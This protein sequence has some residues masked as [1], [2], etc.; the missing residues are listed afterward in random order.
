MFKM[1]IHVVAFC[2]LSAFPCNY[3]RW[4]RTKYLDIIQ[5]LVVHIEGGKKWKEKKNL[6]S[7]SGTISCLR[8]RV[9]GER[10]NLSGACLVLLWDCPWV[11]H[12]LSHLVFQSDTGKPALLR[13]HGFNSTRIINRFPLESSSMFSVREQLQHPTRMRDG[14]RAKAKQAKTKFVH[15][16]MTKSARKSPSGP[17]GGWERATL[18]GRN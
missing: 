15:I 14:D 4:D 1:R 13:I 12:C 9:R 2:P 6:G 11:L 18:A 17:M 5:N 16:A 7:W 8:K 3:W 10:E